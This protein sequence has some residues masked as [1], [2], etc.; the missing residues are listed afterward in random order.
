MRSAHLPPTGG[1]IAPPVFPG[2]WRSARP[3]PALDADQLFLHIR[4]VTVDSDSRLMQ[5]A[6]ADGLGQVRVSLFARLPLHANASALQTEPPRPGRLI[7]SAATIS[8]LDTALRLCAGADLITFGREAQ[9]ALLT[10]SA[11]RGAR[12][13]D[14]ARTRFLKVARRRGLDVSPQIALNDALS[15]AGLPQVRSPDAA[16]RALG[17]RHLS[18][19]MDGA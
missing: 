12:S 18:L 16:L 5:Y 13:L 11:R 19:W 2:L 10:A 17:L 7:P 14:C 6:I 8:E 4:A 1:A 3:A 9:G 15:L